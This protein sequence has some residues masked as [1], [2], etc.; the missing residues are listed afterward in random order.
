VA[1]G[2]WGGIGGRGVVVLVDGGLWDL[3]AGGAGVRAGG[4]CC[5]GWVRGGGVGGRVCYLVSGVVDQGCGACGAVWTMYW[6]C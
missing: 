5:E 4:G 3:E 2:L 6:L 1:V